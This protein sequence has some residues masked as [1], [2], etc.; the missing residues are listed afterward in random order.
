MLEVD[1]VFVCQETDGDGDPQSELGRQK[2]CK[3][4]AEGGVDCETDGAK[5]KE[6]QG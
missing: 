3:Y 5:A 4:E 2:F 6:E 1:E